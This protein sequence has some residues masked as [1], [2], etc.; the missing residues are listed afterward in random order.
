MYLH[1]DLVKHEYFSQWNEKCHTFISIPFWEKK[2]K[3]ELWK[4]LTTNFLVILKIVHLKT[5]SSEK[6]CN[7]C[8]EAEIEMRVLI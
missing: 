2:S 5:A 8:T 3:F 7:C 1:T 6:D 4:N